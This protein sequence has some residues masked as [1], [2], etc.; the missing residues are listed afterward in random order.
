MPRLLNTVFQ[1]QLSQ[2]TSKFLFLSLLMLL[3]P[4]G[5]FA[6]R[7]SVQLRE[8]AT[9]EDRSPAFSLNFADLRGFIGDPWT[10]YHPT[11]FTNNVGNRF[12]VDLSAAL[13]EPKRAIFD[14]NYARFDWAYNLFQFG[15]Y[16]YSEPEIIFPY[17]YAHAKVNFLNESNLGLPIFVALGYKQRIAYN[18]EAK[19]FV[20]PEDGKQAK[21]DKDL[22]YRSLYLA[23]DVRV[24]SL[25]M[26]QSFY[27]DNLHFGLDTK[28]YLRSRFAALLGIW[29]PYTS[30]KG[31]K[32]E[33]SHL[34]YTQIDYMLGAEYL[35]SSF[36]TINLTF[37]RRFNLTALGMKFSF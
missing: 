11:A 18:D 27:T 28:W 30:S 36:F 9:V 24:D 10:Y 23:V 22:D 4:L 7:N 17:S 31:Y 13:K 16:S 2:G 8:G 35:T 12:Y 19:R 14:W 15:V 3:L 5:L 20:Y 34:T 1:S 26:L 6:Q 21:Q 32:E 29:V 33:K 37:Q 25:G